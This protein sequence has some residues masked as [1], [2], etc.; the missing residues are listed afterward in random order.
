MS[1]TTWVLLRGLARESGHWGDFTDRL[2]TSVSPESV[3]T[4]DLPGTGARHRERSPTT[5][6]A[7]V[8]A[9][10]ADLLRRGVMPPY[11][12]LGLSLGGMVALEWTGAFGS[13]VSG[14]IA[15]NTSA[16]ALGAWHE[17]LRAVHWRRLARALVGSDVAR[18]EAAVLHATSSQPDTH[19]DVLLR[20]IALHHQRPVSRTNALRQLCAAA[21]YRVAEQAPR[22]PVLL[23]CGARDTLV[24]P[25]CTHRLAARWGLRAVEHPSG[26][27]D[28]ALDAPDWIVARAV[29]FAAVTPTS[30]D[31]PT[32]AG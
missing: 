8:A 3:V 30:P 12:L 28:L 10:R 19:A 9:C 26:G 4:V 2:A 7:I 21:R 1:R 6:P 18:A 31:K 29:A 13:E 5:V 20:W 23:L 22:P 15:I 17:R 11:R 32:V 14:C 27:H 24:S 16:R 25:L